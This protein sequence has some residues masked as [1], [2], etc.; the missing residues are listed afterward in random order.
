MLIAKYTY[1]L[2]NISGIISIEPVAL[3]FTIFKINIVTALT[4]AKAIL[5]STPIIASTAIV[6]FILVLNYK[7]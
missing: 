2:L 3:A 6:Y 5:L 7:V 4:L 1:T